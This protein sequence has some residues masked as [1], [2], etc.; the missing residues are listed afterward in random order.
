MKKNAAHIG[1]PLACSLAALVVYILTL[2]PTVTFTDAGELATVAVTLGVAHPTGYPLFTILAHLWTLV[3]L[4]VTQIY[5]LNLFAAVCTSLSAIVFFKT[6][7]LL[8]GKFNRDVP[9]PAKPQQDKKKKSKATP[10]LTEPVRL[11]IAAAVTL[12]YSFADTIWSQATA[13]EVYSLHLVMLNLAI[14]YFLRATLSDDEKRSEKYYLIWA[15]VLGL[16]FANHLTTVLLAPAM[17]FGYFRR[18]KFTPQAFRRIAVM[19]VPFLLG[20]SVYLYLPI[21]SGQ[22]PL[23]D[24][25]GVSRS[26][27]Y[28]F[29]HTSGKQFQVWMFTAGWNGDFGIKAQLGNFFMLWPRQFAYIGFVPLGLGLWRMWRLNRDM[30]YF[31]VLLIAGCVTYSVNYSIHDIDSYFVL[32]FTASLMLVALGLQQLWKEREAIAKAF[33]VLPFLTLALNY[34]SNDRSKDYL[35]YD[36]TRTMTDS[37]ESNA[38]IISQ[39]WDY[40]TS[41]FWYLQTVEGYRKDVV[42]VEKE[43]LRRSWYLEQLKRQYPDVAAKSVPEMEAFKKDLLLFE[44]ERPYN[45]VAIQ[46]N[47]ERLINSF[48]DKNISTRP[49]YVTHEVI[50]G[51]RA[52][53]TA[54][55]KFPQGFTLRLTKDTSAALPKAEDIHL[56]KFF[57]FEYS[58]DDH[59][60]VGIHAAV[61][62]HLM[63]DAA[64]LMQKG[65]AEEA[66][67]FF[68][69]ALRTKP[70]D[71]FARQGLDEAVQRLG[72]K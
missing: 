23:L 27:Y 62:Q 22:N 52:V 12:T 53:A 54:Y 61:Y 2:S 55:N 51:E 11:L 7:V 5:K 29:Y 30:F 38:I 13:I 45:H 68:E 35:V 32:A 49:V 66:K 39:Q 28:F 44:A 70:D 14:Y 19:A 71:A 63:T 58:S 64:Y 72:A 60:E 3:P 25:G 43:L 18:N 46:A 34:K 67:K 1:L 69:L 56:E 24:W 31:L 42:L 57:A 9:L 8:L 16:A 33:L 15:A 50:E 40:F 65:Q 47:Y 4:P 36:Y 41:A 20:L 10:L 6:T 21:R 48:I 59:L 26:L 37:L 17:L